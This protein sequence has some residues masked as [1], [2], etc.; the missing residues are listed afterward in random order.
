MEVEEE[1]KNDEDDA[2][3]ET[4]STIEKSRGQRDVLHSEGIYPNF[5]D[6]DVDTE[7][8]CD[9]GEHRSSFTRGDWCILAKFIAK[10]PWHEMSRKERWQTFTETVRDHF[11]G[12]AASSLCWSSTVRNDP[13][14][15]GLNFI[16]KMRLVRLQ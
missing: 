16:V 15:R 3:S 9:M 14:R 8:E 7:D 2:R 10:N 4:V 12:V 5:G 13:R 6:P 11:K 1:V